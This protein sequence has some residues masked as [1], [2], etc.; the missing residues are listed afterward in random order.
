MIVVT[1]IIL[2][3]MIAEDNNEIIMN[4]YSSGLFS[5]YFCFNLS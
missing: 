3:K 5:G 2:V 1:V 4:K